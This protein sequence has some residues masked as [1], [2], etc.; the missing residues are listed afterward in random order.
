[1][2]SSGGINPTTT[3]ME[4]QK[5]A[6]CLWWHHFRFRY[7]VGAMQDGESGNAVCRTSIVKWSSHTIEICHHDP[8]RES[9]TFHRCPFTKRPKTSCRYLVLKS[10]WS[11]ASPSHHRNG[12]LSCP[13]ATAGKLISLHMSKQ[14]PFEIVVTSASTYPNFV[15]IFLVIHLTVHCKNLELLHSTLS[16]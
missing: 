10:I 13:L 12:W 5:P 15:V 1:M 7:S 6:R 14:F 2:K 8:G 16:W 11:L 9:F 4:V 3:I